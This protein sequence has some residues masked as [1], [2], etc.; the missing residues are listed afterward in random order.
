MEYT[1]IARISTFS[2]QSKRGCTTS[3][4][5][6]SQGK[7][8]NLNIIYFVRRKTPDV[9]A[10]PVHPH[11]LQSPRWTASSLQS[12]HPLLWLD[13]GYETSAHKWLTAK[14]SNDTYYII[15]T[16]YFEPS[17]PDARLSQYL[18]VQ[19]KKKVIYIH[20]V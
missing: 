20:C 3:V 10:Y 13:H 9:I 14:L 15:Q 17:N 2:Q 7:L 19:K 11:A 8:C 1:Y 6:L 5:R 4:H 12:T 18:Q 16:T